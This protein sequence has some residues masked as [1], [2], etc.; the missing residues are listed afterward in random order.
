MLYIWLSLRG[1]VYLSVRMELDVPAIVPP[2]IASKRSRRAKPAHIA[3]FFN[4]EQF[5]Q[6]STEQSTGNKADEK[7]GQNATEY[8]AP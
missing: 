5:A 4:P 8:A 6:N 3:V 2:R 7:L 1:G